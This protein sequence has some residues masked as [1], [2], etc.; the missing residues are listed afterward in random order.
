MTGERA[1]LLIGHPGHELRL[2]HWLELERPTVCILTDGSGGTGQGRIDYSRDCLARAGATMGPLFGHMAD[3]DWYA[4]L[5]ARDPEPFVEAG[6][7]IAG[8]AFALGISL[9]VSDT[10][11]GYNPMHDAACC[12]ATMV[13]EGLSA[14]GRPVR[15]LSA[16][17]TGE[18]LSAPVREVRLDAIARKRKEAAMARYAPLL[19]EIEQACEQGLDI[20]VERLY[21]DDVERSGERPPAYESYGSARVADGDYRSVIMAAA[22]YQPLMAE[23]RARL[24]DLWGLS[25][26][27]DRCAVV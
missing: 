21:P 24:F 23:V 18:V 8:A 11:D 10:R 7:K 16:P 3:R 15:R 2:H 6:D 22:H 9:I 12:L 14:Q 5:L 19:Q 13:V 1:M 26:F 4:A 27:P 20:G 17:A 25:S